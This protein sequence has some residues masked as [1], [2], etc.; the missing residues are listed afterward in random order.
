VNLAMSCIC[1]FAT[2][3][4]LIVFAELLPDAAPA[5]D[6]AITAIAM[7]SATASALRRRTLPVLA[8]CMVLPPPEG[9]AGGMSRAPAEPPGGVAWGSEPLPRLTDDEKIT[10]SRQRCQDSDFAV[11]SGRSLAV[12]P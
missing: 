9:M 2:T 12:T 5:T 3:A 7:A 8:S 11:Q 10:L 4:T 1:P 6:A